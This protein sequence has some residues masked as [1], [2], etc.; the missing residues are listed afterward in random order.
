MTPRST[1]LVLLALLGAGTAQASTTAQL[2]ELE[3]AC[4]AQASALSTHAAT[5]AASATTALS[6]LK[7]TAELSDLARIIE[8]SARFTAEPDKGFPTSEELRDG[9]GSIEHF[10]HIIPKDGPPRAAFDACTTALLESVRVRA[11]ATGQVG[12]TQWRGE[13]AAHVETLLRVGAD[14]LSRLPPW[15]APVREQ[16]DSGVETMAALRLGT[17]AYWLDGQRDF[18]VTVT[19]QDRRAIREGLAPVLVELVHEHV[20]P[21]VV[22][23]AATHLDRLC[24]AQLAECSLDLALQVVARGLYES[25]PARVRDW[26]DRLDSAP[27]MAWSDLPT[28]TTFDV[29]DDDVARLPI[30]FA[31]LHKSVEDGDLTRATRFARLA[32]RLI[33]RAEG[34]LTRLAPSMLGAEDVR[35]AVLRDLWFLSELDRTQAFELVEQLDKLLAG[36]LRLR[37]PWSPWASVTAGAS[38]G[39]S[40]GTDLAVGG[41][42]THGRLVLGATVGVSTA[43]IALSERTHGLTQLRAAVAVGGNLVAHRSFRLDL[44]ANPGLRVEWLALDAERHR[45]VAPL[46]GATAEVRWLLPSSRVELGLSAGGDLGLHRVPSVG[47]RLGVHVRFNPHTP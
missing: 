42:V 26:L 29:L 21:V 13:P 22:E 40:A 27:D 2:H 5:T 15:Y 34:D 11:L 45:R 46:L 8:L 3:T 36:G 47:G 41:G 35:A 23:R 38:L 17:T 31:L 30:A 39:A 43:S 33:V 32:F 20:D 16:L 12:P 37:A 1:A 18:E 19:D 7:L 9:I 24:D 10:S 6:G 44:L 4:A 25:R 28:A 14:A